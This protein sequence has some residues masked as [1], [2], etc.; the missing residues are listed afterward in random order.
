MQEGGGSGETPSP[1]SNYSPNP[2]KCFRVC[3]LETDQ[4]MRNG[5]K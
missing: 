3:I 4:E 5:L 1:Y 2:L